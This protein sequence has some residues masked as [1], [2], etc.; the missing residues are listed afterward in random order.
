MADQERQ[1]QAPVE[2]ASKWKLM[3]FLLAGV[4]IPIFASL[5]PW[6]LENRVPENKLSYSLI[7]PISAKGARS[8]ELN[9][10]NQGREPQNNLEIWIPLQI[11][12]QIDPKVLPGGRIELNEKLPSII[13]DTSSEP[14][15]KETKDDFTILHYEKLRP[16]ESL[17]VRLFVIGDGIF[18]NQYELERMRIV[19]DNT[20]AQIDKPSEEL[21]FMFR[22]GS[23]LFVLFIVLL[24]GYGVY[25][26][27][28]MPVDKKRA[29]LQKQLEKLGS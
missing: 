11:I 23:V 12:P 10:E 9:I 21:D 22:V 16:D 28:F 27:K 18:W 7:G 1:Q 25:Y 19:S 5:L 20:L 13:L 14:S 3:S 26:E 6:V 17:D 24:F 29:E 8:F 4:L 2:S 15:K